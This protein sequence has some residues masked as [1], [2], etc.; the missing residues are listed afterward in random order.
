[1]RKTHPII[2]GVTAT[3]LTL[4]GLIIIVW[5]HDRPTT[6]QARGKTDSG[7]AVRLRLTF[8]DGHKASVTAAEGGMIKVEKDGEKLAI[9]PYIRD[10][11][12]SRVELRVFRVVQHAGAETLEAVDTLLIDRQLAKLDRGNLPLGLQVLDVNKRLPADLP[13][14]PAA[15]CCATAC[16]GALVCGVCVCTDCGVCATRNWCDCPPPAPPEE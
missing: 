14:T 8:D 10:Q 3:L 16:N 13:A 4:F 6:P 9:T 15:E 7:R 2:K 5:G 1:M 12:S 11:G